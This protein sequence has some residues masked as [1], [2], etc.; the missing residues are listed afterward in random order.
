[1][2][3]KPFKELNIPA[4]IGSDD[5]FYSTGSQESIG[6]DG[7]FDSPLANKVQFNLSF[8][9]KQKT[10]LLG[11]S[12]SIYYFDVSEGKWNLP[13]GAVDEIL[14]P[15]DKLAFKTNDIPAFVSGAG[16][17]W[18]SGG[19][20]YLEDKIGFDAYGLPVTSGSTDIRAITRDQ[21]RRQSLPSFFKTSNDGS[22][23]DSGWL[24]AA[25][26]Y[27]TVTG[28]KHD[29]SL[30]SW[31][32]N[33]LFQIGN[34][35]VGNVV[36]DPAGPVSAPQ[37]DNL[38]KFNWRDF[39][40]GP[41]NTAAIDRNDDLYMWGY[42]G[43]YRDSYVLPN[44]FTNPEGGGGGQLGIGLGPNIGGGVSKPTKVK[45]PEDR[46]VDSVSLGVRHTI[47]VATDGTLWGCGMRLH[48]ESGDGTPSVESNGVTLLGSGGS[49]FSPYFK[50]IGID[51]DWHSV[52]CGNH[53]TVV[54]KTNGTIYSWGF[55]ARTGNFGP[56]WSSNA[57]N[58]EW[59]CG[60]LG[61]EKDYSNGGLP[62]YPTLQQIIKHV[63][64]DGNIIT[65]P[66]NSWSSIYSGQFH[67]FAIKNNG[68]L[69]SWGNNYWGQLGLGDNPNFV[70]SSLPRQVGR[71]S[72]WLAV[73]GG[74]SHTLALKNDGSLWS[75][76]SNI[77]GELGLGFYTP[78]QF[79]GGSLSQYKSGAS[80]PAR[81]GLDRD[82]VS[83]SAGAFCS[84]ATKKDGSLWAWGYNE[85]G[86]FGPYR[87]IGMSS[88]TPIKIGSAGL[89]LS[90]GEKTDLLTQDCEKS[91]QRNESYFANENEV[92]DLS[93]DKPFLIEKVVVDMPMCFGKGWFCDKT[94]T[95]MTTSS[96]VGY[97]YN[98]APYSTPEIDGYIDPSIYD[99]SV[100]SGSPM[101][102]VVLAEE[103]GTFYD[104]GGPAISVA[105]YA[106]KTYRNNH[107]RD[108]IAHQVVTH[109][110]DV[111]QDLILQRQGP[112][113]TG[114]L[115]VTGLSGPHA[116]NCHVVA[117]T[118]NETTK[119]HT[120]SIRLQL[121]PQITNAIKVVWTQPISSSNNSSGIDITN[122]LSAKVFEGNT[123]DGNVYPS[124][125][126]VFGRGMTG[127][128]SPSGGSIFGREFV[129]TT[130]ELATVNPFYI[131]NTAAR[132]EKIS[133]YNTQV[134]LSS[135]QRV[136]AVS[137][138]IV[139]AN[140]SSPYLLNPKEKLVLSVAKSR[141]AIKNYTSNIDGA[142]ECS[143]TTYATGFN[144]PLSIAFNS[145]GDLFVTEQDKI[146]KVS[147]SGDVTLFATFNDSESN[148][149]GISIDSSDNIYAAC[150]DQKIKKITSSGI[151]TTLYTPD[152]SVGVI[153][154]ICL[155]Q[156]EK[157]IFTVNR[158]SNSTV[159]GKNSIQIANTD[160]TSQY[161]DMLA[162]VFISPSGYK[163]NSI[164]IGES[165]STARFY[166]PISIT[167]DENGFIYVA[168]LANHAIR[169]IKVRDP[170]DY[171]K[172]WVTTHAPEIA[173]HVSNPLLLNMNGANNSTSFINSATP[174]FPLP[175][176]SVT[177]F[178]TTR[179]STTRSKFGGAS[180]YFPGSSGL[181]VQDSS[182]FAFG[183]EDFTIELWVYPESGWGSGGFSD[184]KGT[185]LDTR[186][187]ENSSSGLLIIFSNTGRL[188][189]YSGSL[190]LESTTSVSAG[191]WSH[192]AL[193]RDL[194]GRHTFYING[195]AVGSAT[196]VKNWSNDRM[197]IGVPADRATGSPIDN[198]LTY[199]GYMDDV[200]VTKGLARYTGNFTPPS[201]ELQAELPTYG[202]LDG[203]AWTSRF[204]S[205]VC[206]KWDKQSKMLFVADQ[207]N[208]SI[209]MVT[210]NGSVC[211]IAGP[212]PPTVASGFV[213]GPRHTAR[214]NLPTGIA[215]FTGSI[216]VADT[217]NNAI[218]KITM[219]TDNVALGV[220]NMISSSYTM[221]IPDPK[222]H[223]VQLNT[224]SINI[225]IYGSYVGAGG[226]ILP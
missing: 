118:T 113:S 220:A 203:D 29:G 214:F 69:W 186:V 122:L 2:A 32:S 77:H 111:S 8:P 184:Y 58:P 128:L 78:S 80:S 64:A 65:S 179:I 105:L 135:L 155:S 125:I 180:G 55:N 97:K 107:I 66:T 112:G 143:V 146:K 152:E 23:T 13:S 15:F 127:E 59:D 148:I 68:T 193:V 74:N 116:E 158:T 166:D 63:D 1:M 54:R 183:S 187:N 136:D 175:S 223:D 17:F 133:W 11:N 181:S 219:S 154:D 198:F 48:G 132:S 126:D 43:M 57:Y 137:S 79:Y 25:L 196:L 19:S 100:P 87:E 150:S 171:T 51:S 145:R 206:A 72:D 73:A 195:T 201:S 199:A 96:Y 204:N 10:Q 67:S 103:R 42:N 76:G 170:D 12:S 81:I 188:R 75:W 40:N 30:W 177:R 61:I 16:H 174:N 129:T 189:L 142:F 21:R 130:Q 172:N 39:V 207:S 106:Q 217:G 176:L 225:T 221:P 156:D 119:T 191:T 167:V 60:Q 160:G 4:F 44:I 169:R 45:L 151:I 197:R 20:L 90:P 7:S 38:R 14:G 140:K 104:E 216:Y 192:I 27:R 117:P 6:E 91:T 88:P 178:G 85:S 157:K 92:I 209:R 147:P 141:P 24:K 82:W 37:Q 33:Y 211:T 83:V 182:D 173:R 56:A 202:Y 159:I 102:P 110:D 86:V 28:L 84:F 120:G 35:D 226:S 41:Y 168:E 114:K 31:G 115:L 205:P 224:G 153:R 34:D 149:T 144:S 95:T 222:G 208:H 89:V 5:S 18:T 101:V 50:Q 71:D 108:L 26:N 36:V 194:G 185:I 62:S 47:L 98:G 134:A 164:D 165:S 131:E 200:R 94:V 93:L 3:I 99:E 162:A 9:V 139:G 46:K 213:D 109:A 163:N 218:R 161:L 210:P 138:V 212:K 190:L 49:L 52:A 70:S 124:G 53:H 22:G 215:F 123:K 121:T